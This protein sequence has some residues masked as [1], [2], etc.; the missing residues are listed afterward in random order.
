MVSPVTVSTEEPSTVLI[1]NCPSGSTL[2][3]F[4]VH[5][6]VAVGTDVKL[7]Q[8]ATDWPITRVVCGEAYVISGKP[9]EIYK[10][11]AVT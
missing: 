8:R 2:L 9:E 4:R 11:C 3:P 1:E 10:N 6:T 5:F 7:Q